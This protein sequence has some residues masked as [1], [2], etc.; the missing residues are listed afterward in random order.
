MGI[1][2]QRKLET[3]IAYILRAG[4]TRNIEFRICKIL[5]HASLRHFAAVPWIRSERR[6]LH[7]TVGVSCRLTRAPFASP[8][9]PQRCAGTRCG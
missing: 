9:P 8:C 4:A 2:G 1:R 5:L 3:T 7:A 6:R